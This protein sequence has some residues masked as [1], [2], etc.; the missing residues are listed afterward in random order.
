MIAYLTG[1]LQPDI[2][3]WL[4]AM[5]GAAL[6][7][8]ELRRPHPSKFLL[9]LGLL[10]AAFASLAYHATEIMIPVL[11]FVLFSLL[12]LTSDPAFPRAA[13]LIFFLFTVISPWIL[14]VAPLVKKALSDFK[15]F[16]L[17]FH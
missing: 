14:K 3:G 5:G 10:L 2:W 6:T 4:I 11:F 12:W 9:S 13:S 8:L 17:I 1:F 15:I 7:A 16:D